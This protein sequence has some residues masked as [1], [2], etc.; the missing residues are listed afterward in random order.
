MLL[1]QGSASAREHDA[2]ASNQ[3]EK[4]SHAADPLR[5]LSEPPSLQVNEQQR[6]RTRPSW[7]FTHAMQSIET[8]HTQIHQNYIG[9]RHYFRTE[10]MA[11]GKHDPDRPYR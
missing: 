3:A 6:R 8:R 10:R 1:S 11:G 5:C 4:L 2:A 7:L 9:Q